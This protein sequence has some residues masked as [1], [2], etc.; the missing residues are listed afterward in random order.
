M[1]PAICLIAL[2]ATMWLAAPAAAQVQPL[3]AWWTHTGTSDVPMGG[4]FTPLGDINGDNLADFVNWS[5]FNQ[6]AIFH[7][8]VQPDSTPDL[9][10]HSPDTSFGFF[11][12]RLFSVG[13]VNGDGYSDFIAGASITDYS[14]PRYA[15]LYYGGAAFNS[16]SDVSFIG[17]VINASRFA[18]NGGGLGNINGDDFDDFAILD[19]TWNK[20]YIYYGG[21]PPDSI[22]DVIISADS[23]LNQIG[24]D[25]A[26][27]GDIN[28]DGYDDWVMADGEC[29]FPGISGFPGVVAIYYGGNPPDTLPV[30]YTHGTDNAHLGEAGL[31]TLDWNGDGQL[32]IFATNG[33]F[34]SPNF[35]GSC[36][37]FNVS[38]TMTDQ[39]DHIFLGQADWN[40]GRTLWHVDINNDSNQDLVSGNPDYGFIARGKVYVYLNGAG[41]DTL[42]DATYYQG[43]FQAGLGYGGNVGDI[44]GDGIEDMAVFEGYGPYGRLHMIL[45]SDSLHQSGAIPTHTISIPETS[46]LLKAYP[47]PFNSEV[48]LEIN[49][50][51]PGD[52]HIYIYDLQGRRIKT[53]DLGF[54][55]VYVIWDGTNS[56]SQV[57]AAGIYYAELKGQNYETIIKLNLLK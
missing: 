42:Y 49:A 40:F 1:K 37:E 53:L 15:F 29:Q 10:I 36:W 5:P 54:G 18:Y 28:G 47:N 39:P 41:Q 57:C 48:V 22:S 9:I 4:F 11:G 8:S 20:I 31:T 25:V 45:G 32:D 43:N 34:Y 44:N 19:E 2:L 6:L 23:I 13:D 38:P 7:G 46:E 56:S 30:W 50:P 52:N 51:K 26:P 55:Q 24:W 27:L 17:P 35:H 33:T 16:I 21:N 14:I 3:T 12:L